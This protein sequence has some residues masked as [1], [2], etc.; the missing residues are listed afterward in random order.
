MNL[1]I[2]PVAEDRRWAGLLF[3]SL[4]G[5]FSEEI[6]GLVIRNE[7]KEYN[8]F[9]KAKALVQKWASSKETMST[10]RPSTVDV[11][12]TEVTPKRKYSKAEIAAYKEKKKA[13]GEKFKKVSTTTTTRKSGTS[14]K[15]KCMFCPK[16]TN[17]WTDE[18]RGLTAE[19]REAYSESRK[20]LKDSKTSKA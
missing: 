12:Q 17:H 20:Q 10:V 9:A 8:T 13:N 18:C 6:S 19:Q 14:T 16:L 15:K 3:N 4:N 1:G 7:L 11:R 5:T 2:D